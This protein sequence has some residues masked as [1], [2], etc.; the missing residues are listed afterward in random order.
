MWTHLTEDKLIRTTA[1]VISCEMSCYEETKDLPT[2][3]NLGKMTSYARI[4]VLVKARLMG[5]C[6]PR[7]VHAAYAARKT[8]LVSDES[9]LDDSHEMR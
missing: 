4:C 6:L 8:G 9:H 7:T 2:R 1:G 3:F 5:G